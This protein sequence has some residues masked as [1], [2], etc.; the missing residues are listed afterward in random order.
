[1]PLR[2]RSLREPGFNGRN[3]DGYRD[4]N[5]Q[6]PDFARHPR[7]GGGLSFA[8]DNG[9]SDVAHIGSSALVPSNPTQ[10]VRRRQEASSIFSTPHNARFYSMRQ[11]LNLDRSHQEIRLLRIHPKRVYVSH[12][13]QLFP[14]WNHP[15]TDAY[16]LMRRPKVRN[17][18]HVDAP[19]PLSA[20]PYD[21]YWGSKPDVPDGWAAVRDRNR[22]GVLEGSHRICSFANRLPPQLERTGYGTL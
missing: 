21:Y 1:M 11:Y 13:P 16:K 2:R 15:G 14:Q 18:E 4:D 3:Q 10:L 19:E 17:P 7:R 9:L 8:A 20:R 22:P 6:F 12:L 5:H